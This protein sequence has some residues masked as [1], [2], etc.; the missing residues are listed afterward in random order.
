MKRLS[1]LDA[2]RQALVATCLT[3]AILSAAAQASFETLVTIVQPV[4]SA[5]GPEPAVTTYSAYIGSGPGAVARMQL[6]VA[7]NAVISSGGMPVDRNVAAARNIQLTCV[8]RLDTLVVQ[9]DLSAVH[10]RQSTPATAEWDAKRF[11]EELALTL[12]CGL[13]NARPAWPDVRYVR[14][15]V[16]GDPA[17][18]RYS[19]LYDLS[20]VADY[21]AKNAWDVTTFGPD[22]PAG[23]RGR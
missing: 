2:R 10:R 19:G 9:V 3:V 15:D 5:G 1:C 6:T 7:P 11:A 8:E 16:V 12:W 23:P 18:S 21:V 13:R 22:V 17:L 20:P 14:Y 4:W